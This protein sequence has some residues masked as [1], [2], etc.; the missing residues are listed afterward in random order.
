VEDFQEV[1]SKLDT[2]YRLAASPYNQ[3][4][5]NKIICSEEL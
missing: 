3:N 1:Q 2:H 5:M 4:G